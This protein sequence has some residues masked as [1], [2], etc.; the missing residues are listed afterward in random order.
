M[1]GSIRVLFLALLGVGAIPPS[2]SAGWVCI[3]NELKVAV[4]LQEVPERHR[5]RRG[6]VVKLLPG[7]VYR[8]YHTSAGER[9]V[10]VFDTRDRDKPL[11]S[12]KLAWSAKGDVTYKLE[13]V[14]Q[15]V[16]LVQV[17]PNKP[18]A[19][20]AVEVGTPKR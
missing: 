6:K 20:P 5:L 17:D 4:V 7:E 11:G 13:A 12:A 1:V 19:P 2:A 8:E 9:Q 18:P 15:V 10:Q 14:K 16:R 3:K